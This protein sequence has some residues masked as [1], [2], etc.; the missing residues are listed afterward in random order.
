MA[1]SLVIV[2]FAEQRR[3]ED[4]R[5][6]NATEVPDKAIGGCLTKVRAR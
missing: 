2:L 4:L 3:S 5:R 6:L 1:L